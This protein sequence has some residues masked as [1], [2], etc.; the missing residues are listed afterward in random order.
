MDGLTGGGQ[1]NFKTTLVI[2]L[3]SSLADVNIS[4]VCDPHALASNSLEFMSVGCRPIAGHATATAQSRSPTRTIDTGLTN[5]AWLAF[6]IISVRLQAEETATV[7]RPA[8]EGAARRSLLPTLFA[9]AA[10]LDELTR[11]L[12]AGCLARRSRSSRA[13]RQCGQRSKQCRE[14]ASPTGRRESLSAPVSGGCDHPTRWF[15]S[16]LS[17]STPSSWCSPAMWAHRPSRPR[18]AAR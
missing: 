5:C 16:C 15:A 18:L 17:L 10:E 1:P 12:L 11:E 7:V 2:N 8:F 4:L 6:V 13:T 9:H 3:S 14:R